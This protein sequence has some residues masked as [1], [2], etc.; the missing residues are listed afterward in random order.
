M[1]P[2]VFAVV[3]KH[4]KSILANFKQVDG[5]NKS[6]FSVNAA[7]RP[8]KAS[9][10]VSDCKESSSHTLR[11]D[12]AASSFPSVGASK[13]KCDTP[14]VTGHTKKQPSLTRLDDVKA[15]LAKCGNKAEIRVC[16]PT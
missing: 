8:K 1:N 13:L 10:E 2:I 16:K 4:Y 5:S 14:T 6:R 12:K 15:K 11:G 9:D 7:E 3:M